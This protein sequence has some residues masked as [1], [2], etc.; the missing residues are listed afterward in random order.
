VTAPGKEGAGAGTMGSQNLAHDQIT[1][2]VRVSTAAIHYPCDAAW[3][4]RWQIETV[5]FSDDPR[6]RFLQI[7]HG[8]V[9]RLPA[10][11][12]EAKA[13]RV[14][15]HVARNLREKLALFERTSP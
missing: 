2:E 1:P 10:P 5:V 12:M 8:S 14:H 4:E 13:L 9:S 11:R 6:Q 7:I 3:G 15:G